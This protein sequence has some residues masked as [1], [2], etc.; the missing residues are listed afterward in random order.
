LAVDAVEHLI[1]RANGVDDFA[2]ANLLRLGIDGQ[3]GLGKG[4]SRK[5]DGDE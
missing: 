3:V 1:L 5:Q 2:E 4:D